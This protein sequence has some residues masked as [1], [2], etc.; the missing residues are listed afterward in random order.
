MFMVGLLV[1]VYMILCMGCNALGTWQYFHIWPRV[2]SCLL[3]LL[4]N[5]M[6]KTQQSELNTLSL[7]C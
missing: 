2:R 4:L 3:S 1:H 6:S 5:N 7:R